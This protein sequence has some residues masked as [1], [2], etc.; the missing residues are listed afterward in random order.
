MDRFKK[1]QMLLAKLI[2]MMVVLLTFHTHAGFQ[3]SK[4]LPADLKY[5]GQP[6]SHACIFALV[7]INSIHDSD[8]KIDLHKCWEKEQRG[9]W[10]DPN[11]EGD[12]L[13]WSYVG[14]LPNGNHILYSYYWP[15]QAMGKFSSL[16]IVRRAGDCLEYVG[17]IDGGDRHASGIGMATLS[18]N[19]LIYEKS[20][21]YASVFDLANEFF[22]QLCESIAKKDHA[23]LWCGEAGL[24]GEAAF[25][26]VIS[27]SKIQKELVQF[28]LAKSH[29]GDEEIA[30]DPLPSQKTLREAF[31]LVSDYYLSKGIEVLTQAQFEE[32]FKQII[33]LTQDQESGEVAND[34]KKSY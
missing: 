33:E 15:N 31:D 18:N 1:G 20:L 5:Q 11:Q 24:V 30:L 19:V 14:T 9:E 26:A 3:E 28:R 22:P 2:G 21:T 7:V 12:I 6:V 8:S 27:E 4:S 25:S 34:E 17:G 13:T 32:M 16:S 29:A 23:D 10:C